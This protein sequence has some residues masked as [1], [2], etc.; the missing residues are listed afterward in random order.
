V[1]LNIDFGRSRFT[2]FVAVFTALAVVLD[3][4]PI[5]PGF[6]SGVWD[7]WLFLLSPLFGI[8][9]GPLVGGAS[10]A[11]GSLLGHLIYFRDPFEMVFM[12]GAPLGAMMAGL[13]YEQ[14]W[15]LV[16]SVY[17]LMLFGYFV[18][19]ISWI[20]PLWGVWD[21]IMGFGVVLLY[22][23]M[24]NRQLVAKRRSMSILLA[25]IIGLESDILLRICILV[26]GQTYWFFYGLT[27]EML[28]MLWLG[29]GFVTPIKVLMGVVVSV[30]LGGAILRSLDGGH[31][32]HDPIETP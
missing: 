17:S 23:L 31:R 9:L 18:Y 20:L 26:P 22:S 14:R 10:I 11:L 28:S 6:Y 3:V 29:A 7:S 4:I 21:V 1:A 15:R 8:L 16:L 30:S 13:V 12:L 27:P 5:I 25:S 19:P 32:N 2:S 24:A